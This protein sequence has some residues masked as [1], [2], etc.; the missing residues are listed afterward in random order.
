MA[1]QE[2]VDA[3]GNS[4]TEIYAGPPGAPVLAAS[5]TT[6]GIVL[7]A[8]DAL[9]IPS[10][11]HGTS[12]ETPLII[13]GNTDAQATARTGGTLRASD[14]ATGGAGDVAGAD[15]TLRA[16]KGTGTGTPGKVLIQAAPAAASGD[17]IHV[18]ATVVEASSSGL[19]MPASTLVQVP[20]VVAGN[21]DAAV[22]ARTGGTVRASDVATGGAG[23]VAGADL[24]VR[25]GKGTGTGTPGN[26]VLQAAPAAASGDNIHVPATIATVSTNGVELAASKKLS[27]P[28]AIAGNTDAAVTAR[29][30]GSVRA[31]DVATGGAGNVAG[32]DLTIRAGIGTGTGTPGKVLFLAAPVAA[33]GDNAQTPAQVCE[34]GA[35]AF[36]M[37]ANTKLVVATVPPASAAATGEAGTITWA[38]GFVY[39]CVATNTWQRAAIV[40]W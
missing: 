23:N 32:A 33:S 4:Y 31:P 6:E 12:V 19:A 20:S 3:S 26:I 1:I 39:V 13:A 8:G 37:S 27:S 17:N 10:A 30:G 9:E 11:T 21:A 38:D 40:T 35:A 22:T 2:K 18:P 15:L 36:R 14:V 5:F 7:P 29:T 16:G 34:V 25:P 28:T 24:T